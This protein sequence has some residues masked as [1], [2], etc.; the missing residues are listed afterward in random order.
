[1]IFQII[2]VSQQLKIVNVLL[3]YEPRS[4]VDV[5]TR[6]K[7]TGLMIVVEKTYDEIAKGEVLKLIQKYK[8]EIIKSSS[9]MSL[10]SFRFN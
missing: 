9:N 3:I 5:L 1:M 2:F 6:S 4:Q 8:I 7:K 10:Y